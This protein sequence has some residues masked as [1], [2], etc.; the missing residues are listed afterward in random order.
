MQALRVQTH[1]APVGME[2]KLS[3]KKPPSHDERECVRRMLCPS[4]QH[5][6]VIVSCDCVCFRRYQI[7]AWEEFRAKVN[8]ARENGR[9]EQE[10]RRKYFPEYQQKMQEFGLAQAPTF[11]YIAINW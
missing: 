2:H 3:I 7:Q 1:H 11:S 5:A 10:S 9:G 8:K 4:L 6:S